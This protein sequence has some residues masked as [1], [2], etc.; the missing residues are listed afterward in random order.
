M[1]LGILGN[2]LRVERSFRKILVE[3]FRLHQMCSSVFNSTYP[4]SYL[5]LS[6]DNCRAAF[7]SSFFVPNK[8]SCRVYTKEM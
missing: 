8:T 5:Y 4:C 6:I 1:L 3:G 7:T 2:N